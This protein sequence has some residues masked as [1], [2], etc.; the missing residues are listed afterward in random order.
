MSP[1]PNWLI[2]ATIVIL[3]ALTLS[4]VYLVNK[5]KK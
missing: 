4:G 3:T 5:G 2:V 1:V